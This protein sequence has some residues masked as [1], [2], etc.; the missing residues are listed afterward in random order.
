MS[1]QA[2]AKSI[3]GEF[4]E[5]FGP[6]ALHKAEDEKI[7]NAILCAYVKDFGPLDTISRFFL[8][9]LA[10]YTYEI[11][12]FRRLLNNLIRE[13]HKRELG[14]RG[15]KLVEEAELRISHATLIRDTAVKKTSLEAEKAAAPHAGQ[16][17][18]H[19]HEFG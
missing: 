3:P 6:P 11:Q 9:D 12:W 13:I 1:K 16:P 4:K 15:Q 14:R 10:H 18:G 7:Y 8:L 19:S 2:V 5:L 17:A